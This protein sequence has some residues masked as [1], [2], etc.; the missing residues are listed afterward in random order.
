MDTDS[1]YYK[2]TIE[3]YSQTVNR[4]MALA[5]ANLACLGLQALLDQANGQWVENTD[6][7]FVGS[8][9]V[10]LEDLPN[11]APYDKK[12]LTECFGEKLAITLTK[13]IVSCIKD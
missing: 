7:V 8:D 12:L 11:I 1:R 6:R 13:N 4:K 9:A 5:E 2:V 10:T 3:Y